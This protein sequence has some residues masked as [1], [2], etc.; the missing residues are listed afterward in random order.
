MK[1]FAF[2]FL[3]AL[4]TSLA[5]AQV[6]TVPQGPLKL[7]LTCPEQTGAGTAHSNSIYAG[8]VENWVAANG[9]HHVMAD[10]SISGVLTIDPCTVVRVAPGKSITVYTGGTLLVLGDRI[11]PVSIT[12][13]ANGGAWGSI[14]NLGGV[15]SLSYVGLDS[16]GAMTSAN[17]A[18]SAM[19]EMKSNNANGQF[20]VDN[21]AIGDSASQG[22]LVSGAVGF[23]STSN[24]LFIRSSAY[25][26]LQVQ[27]HLLGSIPTGDYSNNKMAMIA[28]PV[29]GAGG[30]V[31]TTS[32]T[33][34]NR[35]VPY[36][37][38]TSNQNVG[39]LDVQSPTPG[40]VAVLTIE[41]G[42]VLQ[43]PPGGS[44]KID[45]TGGSNI[46]AARGALVAIGTQKEPIVFTSDKGGAAA[47]GDWV[48]IT[49][50]GTVSSQT[51]LQLVRVD[52]A[53]G[54]E[55]GGNSCPPVGR[56]QG[57]NYAAI[58]IYGPPLSQT[59]FV[60]DSI[61]FASARDGIDR[62]WS[63]NLPL[64]KLPDYKSVNSF[65]AVPGCMQSLPKSTQ[66]ACPTA[67]TCP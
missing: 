19:L 66:Y 24:N 37:V 14:R 3:A 43:F 58:R 46:A 27:A 21:V 4:S 23:D 45:P 44:L 64:D 59:P 38:G 49:F 15:L 5:V 62:G 35:G 28:I 20:H 11:R 61:I 13:Q 52:Y 17:L 30:T 40:T 9:P 47:A 56:G 48:G 32:Q 22:V 53:G 10:I 55:N 51:A 60:T 63:A 39:R 41:P 54:A 67:L 31:M 65:A 34:H 42:V 29:V 16:G 50:G 1:V 36:H 26:P 12:K 18:G 25:Y 57:E 8:A 33:M 7:R 2:V 6:R